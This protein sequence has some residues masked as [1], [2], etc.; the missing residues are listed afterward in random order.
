MSTQVSIRP[1]LVHRLKKIDWRPPIT[2][3]YLTYKSGLRFAVTFLVQEI[4]VFYALSGARSCAEAVISLI[5]RS[6]IKTKEVTRQCKRSNRTL[7]MAI[8]S[9][10]YPKTIAL[11]CWDS[12]DLICK[13]P[14]FWVCLQKIKRELIFFIESVR[15]KCQRVHY[16]NLH[17]RGV[18]IHY[19]SPSNSLSTKRTNH[20]NTPRHTQKSSGI[21]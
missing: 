9:I 4:L 15:D 2:D 21:E 17:R 20:L 7:W 18:Q 14:W 13:M 8:T 12:I 19:W 1:L 6:I 10:N 5:R 3:P 16:S 11:F